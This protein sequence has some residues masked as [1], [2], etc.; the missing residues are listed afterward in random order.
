MDIGYYDYYNRLRHLYT[1]ICRED[2]K[3]VCTNS[4]S[5]YTLSVLVITN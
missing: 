2:V 1:F 4:N 5:Y 3:P